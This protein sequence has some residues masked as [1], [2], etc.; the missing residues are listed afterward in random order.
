M[1]LHDLT[2][3]LYKANPD[4]VDD[5]KQALLTQQFMKGLPADTRL[6]LLESNPIPKLEEMGDFLH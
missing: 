2:E 5:A 6:K 3:L 1:Y 4:L